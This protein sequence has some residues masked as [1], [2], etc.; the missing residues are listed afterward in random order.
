MFRQ[1][2]A[3]VFDIT[4]IALYVE[5]ISEKEKVKAQLSS[6]AKLFLMHQLIKKGLTN[7][8]RSDFCQLHDTC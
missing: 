4:C 5:C 1:R 7:F 2:P 3:A 6:V 8:Q